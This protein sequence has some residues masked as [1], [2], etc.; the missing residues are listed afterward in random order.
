MRWQDLRSP[1]LLATL[2]A[3]LL[4]GEACT[5][6]ATPVAPET[7]ASTTTP[8]LV[9]GRF[10]GPPPH[11]GTLVERTELSGGVVHYAW[12]VPV[13][14]GPYDVIR[15]HRVVR[16]TSSPSGRPVA[17]MEGVMLLPGAPQLFEAIFLPPASPSVSADEG[18]VAL[19]LASRE[20]DVWGMD[21]G[22]TAVP[23][24]SPD[25]GFLDGWGIAKD[26]RH[27]EA[28]LTLAR[29]MRSI[30]GQ[31]AGPIHVLGFSYGGFLVFAVAGED[32]QR[33]GNLRNVKGVIPVDG[34]VFAGAPGSAGKSNAC[35]A[36]PAIQANLA[37]GVH[38][39][40][41]SAFFRL[42]RAALDAPDETSVFFPPFTNYQAPLFYLVNIG[43]LGGSYTTAP[44]SVD[45]FFTY[46]PRV[47]DLLA[48]TPPYIPYQWE[49]DSRAA[50]CGSEAYPV[51]FDDHLGDSTVPILFIARGTAGFYTTT[52]TGSSD[53][54][55]LIINPTFDPSLYGHADFFLADD[56]ADVVWQPIL[57]WVWEHE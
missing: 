44:P 37:A 48:G 33:P 6:A 11:L 20:V 47:V 53:V 23:H 55:Q 28:A 21:Y 49:F 5:D 30:S 16:E 19:Y 35:D 31:G 22:W 45:L 34:T 41:A 3:A 1:R 56:A 17:N 42:G 24:G 54:T 32:S 12:E 4:V 27:V 36:L 26:T 15:L 25:A 46:G 13:G 7:D 52:I 2:F 29:W 9:G 43:F 57:E 18:S 10:N 14:T 39:T 8:D 38:V 51:T 50:R 40:D